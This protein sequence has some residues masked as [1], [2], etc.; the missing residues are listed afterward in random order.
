MIRPHIPVRDGW[1]SPK[2]PR[3]RFLPEPGQNE[4]RAG[5]WLGYAAGLCWGAILAAILFKV[6]L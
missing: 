6:V 1:R 4:Y 5:F 2:S 3:P